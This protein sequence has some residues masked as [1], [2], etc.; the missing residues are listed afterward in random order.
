MTVRDAVAVLPAASRAVMVMTFAPLTRAMLALQEFVPVAVPDPPRELVHVTCATPTLSEAVPEKAMGVLLTD[1][2]AAGLL[3]E[4]VG[5]VVSV[6]A[7]ETVTVTGADVV[8]L[9]AASLAT[10]VRV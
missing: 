8:V 7:L 4:T 9:P 5:T 10:A 3:I 6:V 2:L 1:V